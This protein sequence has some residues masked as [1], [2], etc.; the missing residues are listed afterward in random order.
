MTGPFRFSL[1]RLLDLRHAAERAQAAAMG[2]A[3]AEEERLRVTS[4][5]E[6]ARL[7]AVQ[8]QAAAVT[9][10][11]AGLRHLIGLSTEAARA[12]ASEAD[13]AHRTAEMARLDEQDRFSDAR[14]ARRSL[15]R[16]REKR[17]AEWSTEAGRQ[18]QADSDEVARQQ[19]TRK[20]DA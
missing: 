3:A 16:L 14:M 20:E 13:E 6:A 17:S 10:L 19:H 1:Q 12:R 5:Q 18:A 15:E 4:E 9:P 11:P 8:D 2:R 7:E